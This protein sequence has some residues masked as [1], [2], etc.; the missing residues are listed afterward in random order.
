VYPPTDFS[1]RGSGVQQM[2]P[3]MPQKRP[4]YALLEEH[5]FVNDHSVAPKYSVC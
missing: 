3:T 4:N 1:A 2:R 5:R